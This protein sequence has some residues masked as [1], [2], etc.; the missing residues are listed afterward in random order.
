MCLAIPGQVLDSFERRGLPM[1]R[2]RFGGVVREACLEYTPE[3][4]IGDYVLVHVGF[5]ISRVDGA[6]AARTYQL[7]AEM[8]QLAELEAPVVAEGEELRLP[9]GP[10]VAAEGAAGPRAES[11]G[12]PAPAGTQEAA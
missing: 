9:G 5:A 7:L 4:T 8:D 11:G 1:A 10:S 6:E 3:A 12:R 2:I